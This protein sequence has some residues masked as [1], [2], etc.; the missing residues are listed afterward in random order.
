MSETYPEKRLI[1]YSM[2]MGDETLKKIAHE[3]VEA[4]RSSATIDWNLKTV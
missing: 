1:G 3:L 4:V 2:E